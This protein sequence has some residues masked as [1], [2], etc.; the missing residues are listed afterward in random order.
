MNSRSPFDFAQDRLSNSLPR[1]LLWNLVAWLY[2]LRSSLREAHVALSSAAWQESGCAPV[3][4]TILFE[5]VFRVSTR[6]PQNRRSL[7]F[8]RDDK[9]EGSASIQIGCCGG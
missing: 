3:E 5:N 6:G 7:G 8:A 9:G 1:I 2:F 4:M